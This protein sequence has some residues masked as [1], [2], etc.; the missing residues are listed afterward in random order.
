[1]VPFDKIVLYNGE[2]PDITP[3]VLNRDVDYAT[4]GFPPATEAA[5]QQQGIR[6][7]RPPTYSGPALF[8]NLDKLP[9]F[10]DK[11]ARQALAYAIDRNQNGTVSLAASGKGV[12]YMTG[13]SDLLVPNWLSADDQQRLTQYNFDQGQA[14]TLLQQAGWSKSGSQWMTPSGQPAQYELIF[15]AEYADWSASG[16]DVADQLTAF[17]IQVTPRSVTFTQEPDQIDRG[18]FQLGIQGWGAST[19]PHPQFAFVADLFTHNIPTAANLGGR[20]MGFPLQQNTD[21]LGPVDLEQIVVNSALGLDE[22]AQRNNV[23][24]AAIAFNELVP[25]IPLFERYGNNAALEGVRVKSFPA[26]SDPIISNALYGD[27]FVVMLLL[28]GQ[29]QAA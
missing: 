23:T 27:N 1:V 6:I 26:D 14:A 5:F 4:H 8:M 13:F 7:I 12:Q 11:R 15:P 21:A 17:G 9:E 20:G 29:L 3:V 22:A 28:T 18:D 25:M 24:Q 16:Q 2:T 10:G 19:Q